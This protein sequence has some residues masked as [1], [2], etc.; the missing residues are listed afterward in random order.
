MSAQPEN[1]TPSRPVRFAVIGT[2]WRAAF[3]LRVARALPERFQAAGVLVRSPE[4]APAVQAAWDVPVYHDLEALLS[5]QDVCF[6]VHAVSRDS[7]AAVT[8]ALAARDVPVLAETPPAV[9]LPEMLDL[10]ADL[11]GRDA[12]VQVAEQ[13]WLRPHHQAQ[14]AV[15]A[16]GLLG[17]V[18][19][20]QV[21]VA[22]GYHGVS[23]MRRLLGIGFEDARVEGRR[24]A[25]PIVAG[26]GRGGLPA[27]ERIK[28]SVQRFYRLDFGDR[29]GLIDFTGDQYFGWIRNE[30]L[31]VRGER[32]EIMNG[33]VHY[34]K[35]FRTPI[36]TDLVRHATGAEGD[37]AESCLRGY[38]FEGEWLYRNP[39][40]PAPLSDD[41]VAVAH[42][43][44]RMDEYVRTG[45]AFY[46]LAEACQDH[47]LAMLSEQAMEGG[48][49]LAAQRQPW[50][51]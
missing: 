30:R 48:R 27:A 3:F 43:L 14:L 16:R 38:Q 46:S 28:E 39:F 23:L 31:L 45:R 49:S 19:Q 7:K 5:A 47:Y 17:R 44:E 13:V 29:L 33:R 22:H 2:G 18:T 11:A 35:D 10:Y 21:S 50:A 6:A 9:D 12:R 24:F 42:C 4:K 25:A 8:K 34:L 36:R 26:P 1:V 41:E 37:L 51:E 15:T 20:A 32:G 40:A